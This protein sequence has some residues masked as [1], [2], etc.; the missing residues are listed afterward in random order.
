M[1]SHLTN[2]ICIFGNG[3]HAKVVKEIARLNGYEIVGLFDDRYVNSSEEEGTLFATI[4]EGID[5]ALI[6]KLPS[7]IAIGNNDIRKKLARKMLNW[8]NLIHPTAIISPTIKIGCG[9]VIM[10][11]A[12]INADTQVGNH[13]IVN[14][15][16]TVDHDC[17][18]DDFVSIAPGVHLCGGVNVHENVSIGAGAIVIP[19][20]NIK[21]NTTIGAGAV[22]V[23]NVHENSLMLGIPAVNKFEK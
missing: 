11:G 9:N 22:V 10:P 19:Q 23:K 1:E 17:T 21:K 16:A 7:I 2:K 12:I 14:T 8:I 18:I 20:I 4:E 6:E 5:F 15:A 13:C 3:G